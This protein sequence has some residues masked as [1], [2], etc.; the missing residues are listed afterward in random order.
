MAQPFRL[1]FLSHLEGRG[2]AA[3]IYRDT[4][5]L[6]VAADALGFDT[7]W[8]TQHHFKTDG[9]R[10]PAPLPFLAAVAERT[11][12]LRLGIA[13]AVL[14]LEH[15]IRLAE[16]AA[17]VDLLSSGRLELGLGSGFDPFEFRPFGVEIERRRELTT[18]GLHCLQHAFR[19]DDLGGGARLE[20]AV[21]SLADRLWLAVYGV[22][23]A[24][25]AA[26]HGVGLLI[27]RSVYESDK[28][29]DQIQVDWARAY[30]QTATVPPRVGLSRGIYPATDRQTAL[31]GLREG[32]GRF[33][34]KLVQSGRAPAGE[35]LVHYL[36]RLHVIYGHPDEVAATLAADQ[37]LPFTTDLIVQFNP[38]TPPLGEALHML[39][40]VATQIAPA[41]GWRS[42]R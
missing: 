18:Q 39:E 29:S 11:R 23:G 8:V 25:Y 16:D 13:V 41:L 34:E 37:V 6:F 7:G 30:V 17:V 1:G 27:N 4:I 10:L 24:R 35:P 14:P 20:P 40:Q 2:E 15:P 5:E 22:E 36:Q 31:A 19:S 26:E 32:V 21:P 9:G 12:T 28:P 42:Q 38:A 3:Q 33:A